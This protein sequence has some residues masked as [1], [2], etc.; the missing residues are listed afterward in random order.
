MIVRGP[1]ICIPNFTQYYSCHLADINQFDLASHHE[2]IIE[3]RHQPAR[4]VPESERPHCFYTVD[5]RS[6]QRPPIFHVSHESQDI[7]SR[8]YKPINL[9]FRHLG[10]EEK[11]I[12]FNPIVDNVLFRNSC[13][14]KTI[15]QFCRITHHRG[16]EITR[17]AV[18]CSYVFHDHCEVH[19]QIPEHGGIFDSE[20]DIDARPIDIIR[21]FNTTGNENMA[22]SLHQPNGQ[23]NPSSMEIYSGLPGLKELLFVVGTHL[24]GVK[25]KHIDYTTTFRR[26]DSSAEKDRVER[27]DKDVVD[28]WIGEYS[29][30]QAFWEVPAANPWVGPSLPKF[31]FI[32]L[33]H[34]KPLENGNT[35][36]TYVLMS[37]KQLKESGILYQEVKNTIE[38]I[39]GCFLS[40]PLRFIRKG[41]TSR[42]VE[43]IKEDVAEIGLSAPNDAS[44]RQAKSVLRC[45][46]AC[47]TPQ[48]LLCT[49][50][51]T[52]FRHRKVHGFLTTRS[53]F[54]ALRTTQT[55]NPS[56][57]PI[58][59]SLAL[60]KILRITRWLITLHRLRHTLPSNFR[61][62]LIPSSQNIMLQAIDA[63]TMALENQIL[64]TR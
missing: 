13:C 61:I 63:V 53:I 57:T 1:V 58:E 15:E 14:I 26:V 40:F 24:D 11:T 12:M 21:G 62:H 27:Q 55:D 4:G 56:S 16:Q 51:L 48:M 18:P 30:A 3:I 9:E 47:F 45:L 33:T 7:A 42:N 39:T 34:I 49:S 28:F 41:P 19:V 23:N 60:M 2:R 6:Y 22:W 10:S 43:A 52:C 8:H 64:S 59:V 5:P 37:R 25:S 38:A 32:S 54:G 31:S 29:K 46:L 35:V 36:R 44:I 17:V 50:I 20:A